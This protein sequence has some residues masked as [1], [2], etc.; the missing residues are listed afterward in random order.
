M[1]NWPDGTPIIGPNDTGN[2][3]LTDAAGHALNR[4]DGWQNP[5]RFGWLDGTVAAKSDVQ[6]TPYT[7]IGRGSQA[8]DA[9][10]PATPY[11]TGMQRSSK[12]R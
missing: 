7:K 5:Q 4:S 8:F 2:V 9:T 11:T 3:G 6:G 12:K 10:P 1:A